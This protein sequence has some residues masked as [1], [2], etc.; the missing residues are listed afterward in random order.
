MAGAGDSLL[1]PALAA[2]FCAIALTGNAGAEEAGAVPGGERIEEIVVTGSYL[3]RVSGNLASPL[4][5]LDRDDL[6]VIGATD[7]K[8]IVRNM[9]F[10]AGSLGVSATNWAGDDSSTGNASV[11]LRN[12]G[13]GAT[14]VLLNGRRTVSTSFDNSG[15]SYVDVQ[16]LVPNIAL[17]RV[18]P[19]AT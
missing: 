2:L 9:N 13:N 1:K 5:V 12:L 7:L 19:R 10:N 6:D 4:T 15:S 11:N 16:G 14:L 17:E 3:R 18:L 8:E